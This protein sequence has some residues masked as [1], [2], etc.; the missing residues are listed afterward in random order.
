MSSL[1]LFHMRP[2]V[3]PLPIIVPEKHGISFDT[4]RVRFSVS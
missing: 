3:P 1:L 4:H 2:M